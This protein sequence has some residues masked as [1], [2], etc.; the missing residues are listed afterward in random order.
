MYQKN[1][2][3]KLPK[4]YLP[5]LLAFIFVDEVCNNYFLKI[6][7]SLSVSS[8]F[9]EMGF[10]IFFLIVQII[11]SPI[12]AG[13]SDFYCRKKSLVFALSFSAL[14]LI[15]AFFYFKHALPP[16]I[17]LTIMALIKG[18][19]GNN[20]PLS[21]AGI[22]DTQTSNVRISLALSTSAIALGYLGLIGLSSIFRKESLSVVIFFMFIVLS[23]ICIKKF[24]DIRDKKAR[25]QSYEKPSLRKE[26]ALIINNF[27]KS[28]RFRKG[29]LV[30]MFWEISFYSCHM[31]DVDLQI[32]EFKGLTLSMVLGYL[33]GVACLWILTKK[34]DERMIK[35]GYVISTLAFIPIF[36]LAPFVSDIT[37]LIIVCYFF[38]ALG[39][40]F[41][42]PS[43]FSTLSKERQSYEQGKIYG[44][45]D[46]IDTVAFLISTIITTTY[47]WLKPNQLIIV[48]IS[49]IALLLSRW[50]YAEFKKAKPT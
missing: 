12:Q 38:Y 22:A 8:R 15:P 44:L 2:E 48:F 9:Q 47:H 10:Y 30:F 6:F 31:L 7:S 14:S 24:T 18:V 42:A 27:L 19:F 37:V 26:I 20:L 21:W 13:Y 32:K 46:S 41:L 39:A 43:L 16:I 29:L 25:I 45:L 11:F 33:V 23:C 36:A 40:A 34:K 50:P 35:I 17:L 3:S 1:K 28:R 49:F 5:Q 4:T